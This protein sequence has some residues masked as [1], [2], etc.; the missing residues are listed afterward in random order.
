MPKIALTS[1]WICTM[2][3]KSRGKKKFITLMI[4]LKSCSDYILFKVLVIELETVLGQPVLRLSILGVC[5]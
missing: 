1:F 4:S 2:Q 5:F 3:L